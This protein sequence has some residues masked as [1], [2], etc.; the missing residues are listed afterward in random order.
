MEYRAEVTHLLSKLIAISDSAAGFVAVAKGEKSE[1]LSSLLD[2]SLVL[3]KAII[4]IDA[5]RDEIIKLET[6][7][8]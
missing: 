2:I 5:S 1:A 7:T 3:D 8:R 6:A 4:A